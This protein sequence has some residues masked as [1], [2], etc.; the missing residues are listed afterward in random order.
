MLAAVQAIGLSNATLYNYTSVVMPGWYNNLFIGVSMAGGSALA[1]WIGE[2]ITEKGIGNGISLLIFVGIVGNLIEGLGTSVLNLFNAFSLTGLIKLIIFVVAVLIIIVCVTFVDLGER[3][4][5]LQIAKQVRGRRSYGGQNTHMGLKIVSVGVLPLIFASSFLSFPSIIAQFTGGAFKTWCENHLAKQTDWVYLVLSTLLIVA[6]T[7]FYSSISF[8][9]KKQAQQLQEQ[10]ATIPGSRSK[11]IE[12]YLQRTVN[13]LNLF[14]ALF[15]AALN[16]IG[17][18]LMGYA[19]PG[20]MFAASSVLIA[21][22]VS[23]ETIRTMEGEMSIR[24]ID[25]TKDNGFM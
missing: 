14:A 19:N 17:S 18:L 8:D 1:M 16:I 13:R 25:T 10:G 11:N 21:V 9:A 12:S 24:G 15:L 4:V 22:S 2:K 5:P 7:F 23:L 3:R 6:F 20:V